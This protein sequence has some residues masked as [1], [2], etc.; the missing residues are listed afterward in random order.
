[1]SDF[2]LGMPITNPFGE[3]FYPS[4]NHQIFAQ[5]AAEDVFQPYFDALFEMDEAL[6]VV[7]GTDSG[8]LPNFIQSRSHHPKV[9]WLFIELESVLQALDV[10]V[11]QASDLDALPNSESSAAAIWF[12]DSSFSFEFLNQAFASYVLRRKVF[13]IKSLAVMDAPHHSAYAQLWEAQ[14][15]ALEQYHRAKAGA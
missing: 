3:R 4:I 11:N 2:N 7:V 5:T 12:F 9:K 15:I 8:L 14:Q 6:F 1:M 13:L 10:C